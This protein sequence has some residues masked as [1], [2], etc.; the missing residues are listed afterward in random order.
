MKEEGTLMIRYNNVHLGISNNKHERKDTTDKPIATLS[1]WTTAKNT[2]ELQGNAK[3]DRQTKNKQKYRSQPN[4]YQAQCLCPGD[5][6]ARGK[7]CAS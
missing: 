3:Y 2:G 1:R 5:P 4:A 6:S 7:S